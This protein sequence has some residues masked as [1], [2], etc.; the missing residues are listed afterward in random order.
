MCG[1]LKHNK[2]LVISFGCR[3]A[4]VK[5]GRLRAIG[6]SRFLKI[7]FGM[8]Y[9]L[10]AS[11]AP[12]TDTRKIENLISNF[13]PDAS[14]VSSAGTEF[15]VRLSKESAVVFSN[16]FEEID[17]DGDELGIVN[18]GIET[19]TL[20]EVF[21][22]IVNEDT[23]SLIAN[24]QEANKLLGASGAER[25]VAKQAQQKQDEKRFPL[26]EETAKLLLMPGH[27]AGGPKSKAL[28][29]Q[30]AI[31]VWKRK[32][33]FLRSKGQWMMGV[34]VPL[35]M[36]L[37]SAII[38]YNIPTSLLD[39]EPGLTDT[40]YTSYYATP[41]A[42]KSE[43]Q[44]RGW[45]NAAGVTSIEYVGTNYTDLYNYILVE[46]DTST[47]ISGA[48]VFYDAINNATVMYNATYPLWYPGLIDGILQTA[49]NDVTENKLQ[50]NLGCRPMASE[51]L[52]EQV[53][54]LRKVNCIV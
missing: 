20:E 46:T 53:S 7:R 1:E 44:S 50:I 25:D 35:A 47:N 33:Q 30:V 45:A 3:I 22:R 54:D 6:S 14:F 28:S 9:L 32:F 26:T 5:E 24:H 13:V 37:I 4:I 19:T 23:E 43:V 11:L 40:S 15:S 41:L 39:D 52:S 36:I 18:Y 51:A 31:L 2:L 8:G 38:M 17:R 42:G 27:K 16:L 29:N 49:V 48:G 21:M 12:G 34:V 10:R